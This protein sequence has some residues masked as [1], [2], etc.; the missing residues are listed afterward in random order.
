MPRFVDENDLSYAFGLIAGALGKSG[1][2]TQTA[3][4]TASGWSGAAP[5][6]QAVAVA[7]LGAEAL[8]VV[9][10]SH[11]ATAA[12]R[13]ACRAARLTPTAQAAGSVTVTADGAR[14]TVDIPICI[15]MWQ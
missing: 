2:R 9:G 11:S 7:G 1:V 14:P 6:T 8:A 4:L 10:L 13:E 3:T 12:Q 5:C 15:A